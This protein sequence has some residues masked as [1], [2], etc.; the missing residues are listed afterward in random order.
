ME[1]TLICPNDGRIELGLENMTAIVFRGT[2][3]VEVIFECPQCGT[4]LRAALNVPN[5]LSAALELAHH[6]TDGEAVSDARLSSADLPETAERLLEDRAV[7]LTRER[8]GEAYCEYFR[9]QLAHVRCV[10]DFL[11]ETGD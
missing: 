11:A 3:S 5:L 10:E 7:R 4:S 9:R 6:G 1:F 2:E 8:Q